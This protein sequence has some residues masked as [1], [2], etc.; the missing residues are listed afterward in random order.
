VTTSLVGGGC[1]FQAYVRPQGLPQCQR[2]ALAGITVSRDATAFYDSTYYN[3]PPLYPLSSSVPVGPVDEIPV[4]FR[5]MLER[6]GVFQFIPESEQLASP[7]FQQIAQQN[8]SRA[9][10]AS[11]SDLFAPPGYPLFTDEPRRQVIQAIAAATQ[12]DS[13][14][15]ARV[16]F[17]LRTTAGYLVPTGSSVYATVDVVLYDASG[18]E[19][20][21]DS[22]SA[23]GGYAASFGGFLAPTPVGRAAEDGF[24]S[25][26]RA[27]IER[28]QLQL[29]ELASQHP[30]SLQGK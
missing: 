9:A 1:V 24:V 25:A 3:A 5:R 4:M 28:L 29:K 12:A 23:E 11:E 30:A 10:F 20:W 8:P 18:D 21:R 26:T 7:G 19:A 16:R 6:S 27:L 13:V 15:W 2:V 14:I 22:T 17:E